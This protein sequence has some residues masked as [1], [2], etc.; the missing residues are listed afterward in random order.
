MG[1]IL[2]IYLCWIQYSLCFKSSCCCSVAK[3]WL[4]LRD[5]MDCGMP[6]FPVPHCRPEFAQVHVP[7]VSDAIQPSQPLTPS[8]PLAFSLSQH[9]G[10]F[11][12]V[13]SSHQMY[14]VRYPDPPKKVISR[15]LHGHIAQWQE[16]KRS[17][18]ATQFFRTVWIPQERFKFTP[19]FV[20]KAFKKC[21]CD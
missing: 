3:W 6:G 15:V 21:F 20:N 9:Q 12:W 13:G 4:I 10:L 7:W 17:S 1:S 14:H 18:W 16:G 11:W 5:P 19:A 8:S 2:V